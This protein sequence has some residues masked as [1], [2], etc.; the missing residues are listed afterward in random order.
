VAVQNTVRVS[1]DGKRDRHG[2]FFQHRIKGAL[3]KAT[4]ALAAGLEAMDGRRYAVLYRD[5]NGEAWLVGT[6][7]SPLSFLD[8]FDS[9]S[10]TERNG[11]DWQFAADTDARAVRYESSWVVSAVGLETGL[12][13]SAGAG[14][15]VELRTAGGRLLAIVPAGLSI[16]LKSGFSLSY[17]IV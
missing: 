10:P 13:L 16:V 1:H 4:G 9:G 6:P 15:T 8:K 2:E 5:Q 14:G 11:Y 17:A 7:G 12:E 3:A